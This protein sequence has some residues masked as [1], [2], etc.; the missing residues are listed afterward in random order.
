MNPKFSVRVE[1]G[2]DVTGSVL[3]EVTR[4]DIYING[5]HDSHTDNEHSGFWGQVELPKPLPPFYE[6]M[7]NSTP[8]DLAALRRHSPAAYWYATGLLDAAELMD[9]FE[10]STECESCQKILSATTA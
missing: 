7:F 10:Y 5:E 1:T 6:E 2:P 8:E 3:P 4:F 9:D